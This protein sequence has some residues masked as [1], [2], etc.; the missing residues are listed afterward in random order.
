MTPPSFIPFR[1]KLILVPHFGIPSSTMMMIV[2]VSFLLVDSGGKMYFLLAVLLGYMVTAF[3]ILTM[4]MFFSVLLN[5]PMT[6]TTRPPISFILINI[7]YGW[8][9]V[10][11]G[12]YTVTSVSNEN[13]SKTNIFSLGSL[14]TLLSSYLLFSKDPSQPFWYRIILVASPILI[15]S[16]F[17]M[18]L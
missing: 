18:Y 4:T 5:L 11:L 9:G 6:G 7:F 15:T 16:L 3:I 10:L 13:E 14:M 2:F 12:C 1:C 8:I 17:N